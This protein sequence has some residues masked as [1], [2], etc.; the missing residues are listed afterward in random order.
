MEEGKGMEN[1]KWKGI[2][3]PTAGGDD[4]FRVIAFQLQK[5][6]YEADSDTEG[7]PERVYSEPEA[8]PMV[9]ISSD[10]DTDYT[11]ESDHEFDSELDPAVDIRMEDDVCAPNDIDLD[12]D[13]D[14]IWDGKD[15]VEENDQGEEDEEEED[16]DEDDGKEA[17]TIGQRDI[18]YT[19]ADNVDTIVD[20][21][22][23]VLPEQGQKMHKHTP[24]PHP[25]APA[26]RPQTLQLHPQQQTPATH[27]LS[28]CVY[29][30]L[31][32]RRKPRPAVTTLEEAVAAGS[33]VHVDVDQELLI[34]SA[35]GE[36]LSDVPG[37]VL[38]ICDVPL[39]DITLL[40]VPL[41]DVLLPGVPLSDIPL[42]E[43]LPDGSAGQ[44]C[45]GPGIAV[46]AMVVHYRLG[47]DSCLVRFVCSNPCISGVDHYTRLK[48]FGSLKV[49]FLYRFWT[50]FKFSGLSLLMVL[51]DI[52]HAACCQL[53]ASKEPPWHGIESQ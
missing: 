42:P 27:L 31:L 45:N 14:I 39:P 11:E 7:Y 4:G 26:P 46:V 24:H 10:D 38:L 28:G 36:I 44:V 52:G 48:V 25:P 30:R 8:W 22:P 18:I 37:A 33:T 53:L 23:I 49:C 29:L 13:V 5:D 12:S 16:E 3:K 15:E 6:M 19:L 17:R 41:T 32:I 1:G 51:W 43:A 20:N 47:S 35:G 9:P 34:E 2:V 50:G 40:D 21:Q